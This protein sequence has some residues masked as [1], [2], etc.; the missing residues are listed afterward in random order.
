LI[1]GFVSLV[2]S[3]LVPLLYQQWFLVFHE[4]GNALL[5][6][7]W[8]EEKDLRP[9]NQESPKSTALSAKG[10]G[11]GHK[12]LWITDKV[13]PRATASMTTIFCRF[14]RLVIYNEG[15]TLGYSRDRPIR[16]SSHSVCKAIFNRYK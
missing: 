6:D 14:P 15:F 2:F 9:K 4:S 13:E 12:E 16:G 3:F 10:R 11:H 7:Q 5:T 1:L 8:H